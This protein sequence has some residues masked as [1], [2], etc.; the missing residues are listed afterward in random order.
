MIQEEV[1]R[2]AGDAACSVQAPAAG[3]GPVGVDR[4]RGTPE[5]PGRSPSFV[6]T[7][8]R[9]SAILPAVTWFASFVS[10]RKRKASMI[11]PMPTSPSVNR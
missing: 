6:P 1:W 11:A 9:F 5:G 8:P 7:Y 4:Q 2:G 3:V 10:A